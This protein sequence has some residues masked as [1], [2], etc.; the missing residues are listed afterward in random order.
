MTIYKI[1]LQYKSYLIKWNTLP[2]FSNDQGLYQKYRPCY[3]NN[4]TLYTKHITLFY[5]Y[6]F[7]NISSYVLRMKGHKFNFP[8]V[9]TVIPSAKFW[10]WSFST[11]FAS[12]FC[13]NKEYCI[14]KQ[15]SN[16]IGR[17]LKSFC[18]GFK[19]YANFTHPICSSSF[20][21]EYHLNEHVDTAFTVEFTQC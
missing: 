7:Y 3:G 5:T 11:H 13:E 8:C 19:W 2:R 18:V 9:Y 17:L 10:K 12:V 15:H 1:W 14:W 4:K 21:S 16:P 6:I 20:W